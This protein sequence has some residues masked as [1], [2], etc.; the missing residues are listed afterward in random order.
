VIG[1]AATPGAVHSQR[2]PPASYCQDTAAST[3]AALDC[4]RLIPV[5]T[6]PA[7]SGI[8]AVHQSPSPFDVAVGADGSPRYH[9]S[10]IIAGLP[11]PRS[12]GDFS[13]YV[14]WA[15]TLT[16]D[17]ATKLGSV[18]NGRVDL[19]EVRFVQF[20][21]I[22]SAERSPD[23]LEREGRLVLRGTSP[24]A[25]VLAHRDFLQPSAPGTATAASSATPAAPEHSMAHGTHPASSSA[26]P[27]PPHPAWLRPM[28]GMSSLEPSAGPF[29]PGASGAPAARP[30]ELLRLADGDTLALEA[31]LVSRT[32]AGRSF[33]MYGFNGQYPGP[34]IEVTQGAT[35]IVRFHNA[36]DMPS[37][38]HWHGL[39]LDNRFD[40][41]P[42]VTQ[43][44]VPPG[45]DFTYTVHFPDAGIY[46]YHPH[47]REDIQQNL[48][49][50]GN[51][52]VRSPLGGYDNPVN[53][54]QLLM[55]GDLLLGPGGLTPFGEETPTHALM[56]RFGNVLLVNGEPH[57]T[58][59]V[60]RGEIVRF[61]LTNASNSRIYNV[62][63]PDARMKVVASDVGK[64]EREEW[65]ESVVIAPAQRYVVEVE[66]AREGTVPLLN[67]VIA[68]DHGI[69]AYF[70]EVDTLG[71][72]HVDRTSAPT[73]HTR[74]FE[75]LRT[76]TKVAADI[77]PFRRYFT[78]EP[79]HAL[80]LSLRTR[81]L[82]PAV[83]GMLLGLNSPV[84]W[85]DGMPMMNWATSGNEITWVLRDPVTGKENMDID[86]HFRQGDVVKLRFLNDPS[87][88]HAMA[89]PI[90]LH[91]QRFLVL[92][93]DGVPNEN[94]VWKDT[95]LIPAGET[96]DILVD[97]S[98]PG[99][100]M[101]HCHIAEHLGA[102]MHTV[103]TVAPNAAGR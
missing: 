60:K 102:G 43:D 65:V 26:W 16:L 95:A 8:V 74:S 86:W 58:L 99:K 7:T 2:I 62:S 31:G 82:P 17:S 59:D 15:Y 79:D 49:L 53:R 83:Q 57:Y 47:V 19:G 32:F 41:A 76:N 71:T 6:L 56:G 66:F 34:L 20:R 28:P 96:V 73:L 3:A 51:M 63:F 10:A 22:I 42:G 84:E 13:T 80:V 55:L 38:V 68:L 85:N 36:L 64:F 27:M 12:L 37:S 100:W 72:V 23:V 61:Y 75:E 33:T 29:L 93:R 24:S 81:D 103:V 11:D 30:R 98:N 52:L 54:E 1:S 92:S 4:M 67:R 46:W 90:H 40:G 21:L 78:R 45:G 70:A 44:A 91:G 48:G 25:H 50:Y 101:L 35:I 18:S 5:P 87:T 94:L 69:G 89:H 97:M 77:A 88:S 14:A 9:L 39:R